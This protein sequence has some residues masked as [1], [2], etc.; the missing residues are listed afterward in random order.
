LSS[1]Q[2]QHPAKE[3]AARTLQKQGSDSSIS[4]GS[5]ISRQPV[6]EGGIVFEHYSA[7]NCGLL[8]YLVVHKNYRGLGLDRVL[9][10]SALEILDMNAKAKGYLPGCNAIF[11]EVCSFLVVLC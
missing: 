9:V 2:S 4:T 10:E 7:N 5:V 11:L 6:I 1:S 3:G 8:T